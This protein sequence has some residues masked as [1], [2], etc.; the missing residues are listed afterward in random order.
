MPRYILGI[1]AS[2]NA[3]A[4]IGD[5]SGLIHA[6]QEE[7]LCGEKNY[8]GFPRLAVQACLDRV[9]VRPGDLLSTTHG[10]NQV[11]CRYHSRDDV[12]HAYRRQATL[13]GKLRQR[14]VVPLVTTV[15]RN[16]GQSQLISALAEAGFPEKP[17]SYHDHH[18]TH[19]ATAYYGLRRSPDEKYLVLTCDGA[20]DNVSAS[21]RVW[22]GGKC[23]EIAITHTGD[24][25]GAVYTWVTYGMGF[26]PLEHEY[27]L[28]GMGPYASEKAARE[29][30]KIFERY[31]QLRP[32]GLGFQRGTWRQTH[33]IHECLE[34]D[35]R[36]MRFDYICAGLQQFTEDLMC[37]W[38]RR[39]VQATGVRKVLA[40]GGVFMN[41]K[42]N[43]RIAE[44]AEV[45]SF[46]AFPSCGDETLSIGA[47][48]LE[49]AQHFGQ[50]TV[51]PLSH[52]YLGDAP[53]EGDVLEAVRKSGFDYERP[54]DMADSVARLLAE[55]Q[56][57]ARCA[58]PMEFGARA[59]GNR[60]ILADP[61]SQ[62]V[63]RVINRMVK[64]R[65]FWMPF[66]PMVKSERQHDYI[67]NPKNLRSPFMMMTFDTRSNFRELI[68]AVH[69]ADLTCRAQILSREENPP[70][71][72]ILEAFERHTGGGIVLNTS[73]NLHGFPIVRTAEEALGV[74]RD[75]GLEYLQVGDYLVHKRTTAATNGAG[76]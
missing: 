33:F 7:R 35:L 5:E 11:I 37:E 53:A 58:G 75:S 59:L 36:G 66:A 14:V 51:R 73:F 19:A 62:D 70:M 68:A 64:K 8:W 1:H 39:A 27:K 67:Q 30:A 63:V 24:S 48:Y 52:F 54:A 69:N 22:G 15:H 25:L 6:V 61:R 26:V 16:Y 18:L 3:S 20:G 45:E 43:K 44:L 21:V 71:Y 42:A 17:V 60:S 31:L 32:D 2:H 29:T 40:A 4:C 46:E 41:V 28:M 12:I 72:A 23:D 74:L 49:A 9:G 47:Y 13:V 76:H 38:V 56:P 55:G 34:R 50:E 65:D 10:G 57:V